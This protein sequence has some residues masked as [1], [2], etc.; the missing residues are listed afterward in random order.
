MKLLWKY[1]KKTVHEGER[2]M[3]KHVAQYAKKVFMILFY[4]IFYKQ[5]PWS[6]SNWLQAIVRWSA[7]I[8]CWYSTKIY[9]HYET[10]KIPI[11]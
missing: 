4:F 8:F 5:I 3:I 2:N 11:A 1:K 6:N 7:T 10:I 9:H